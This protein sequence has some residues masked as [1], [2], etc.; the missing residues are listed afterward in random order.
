MAKISQETI[1]EIRNKADIVDIIKEY[2]PLIQKGKNYFGVCPFHQ[3]HS[4]SMSV[5]K[6]R[7]LF[8]CFS[9]GA[10]GNVFKFVSDY[11]NISYIEAVS[12][13]GSKVGINLNIEKPSSVNEK[14]KNLYEIM[15]LTNL[16][17]ENNIQTDNGSEARNYLHQRGLSDNDIKEFP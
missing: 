5:S 6:E 13:V 17:F 7:Q 1:D 16:F 10:G 2:I 8:K 11:E 4:P 3:D 12:K 9:C 15:D 14:Y